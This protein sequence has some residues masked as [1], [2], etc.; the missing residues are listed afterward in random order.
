MNFQQFA[1]LVNRCLCVILIISNLVLNIYFQRTF[2]DN[3]LSYFFSFILLYVTFEIHRSFRTPD[4]WLL[5]A[6]SST[7]S[8]PPLSVSTLCIQP[9]LSRAV[10]SPSS[11]VRP[12]SPSKSYI[13]NSIVRILKTDYRWRIYRIFFNYGLSK[14]YYI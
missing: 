13:L 12:I 3:I 4:W 9:I 11:Y 14:I 5:L 2:I 10:I 6:L 7:W 8:M 1:S